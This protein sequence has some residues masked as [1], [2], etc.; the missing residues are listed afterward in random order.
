METYYLDLKINLDQSLQVIVSIR[1]GFDSPEAWSSA[2]A[3]C[4]QMPVLSAAAVRQVHQMEP[5]HLANRWDTKGG[6]KFGWFDDAKVVHFSGLDQNFGWFLVWKPRMWRCSN[7]RICPL[8]QL[9]IYQVVS[10]CQD[11]HFGPAVASCSR[12]PRCRLFLSAVPTWRWVLLRRKRSASVW[13]AKLDLKNWSN[14]LIEPPIDVNTNSRSW[15]DHVWPV[16]SQNLGT[17]KVA[18]L[19]THIQEFSLQALHFWFEDLIFDLNLLFVRKELGN[20]AWCY[21][22]LQLRGPAT[23]LVWEWVDQVNL[24]RS[25]GVGCS[26][27]SKR[28]SVEGP[29]TMPYRALKC[30]LT[31]GR[32]TNMFLSKRELGTK[33]QS[34]FIEDIKCNML[35]KLRKFA[36]VVVFSFPSHLKPCQAARSGSPW[37]WAVG[38]MRTLWP[39][40]SYVWCRGARGPHI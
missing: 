17:T 14:T 34:V 21:G 27:I 7:W 36:G 33:M 38:W 25:A 4:S 10:F 3:F 1:F 8:E 37:P 35:A 9:K 5:Q 40:P 20:I 31:A 12:R 28:C 15:Y 22:T 18:P 11:G 39:P 2:T 24:L 26:G 32:P 29:G 13:E 30:G 6:M 23:A 19:L 16:K